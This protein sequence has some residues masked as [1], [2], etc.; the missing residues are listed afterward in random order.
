[1]DLDDLRGDASMLL[2]KSMVF[3]FNFYKNT[4]VG[5]RDDRDGNVHKVFFAT[6]F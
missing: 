4:F 3:V 1:M 6:V 5:T 2:I